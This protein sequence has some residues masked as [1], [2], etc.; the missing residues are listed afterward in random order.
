MCTHWQSSSSFF[1]G[2]NCLMS[3]LKEMEKSGLNSIYQVCATMIHVYIQDLCT[4][5]LALVKNP[6][7]ARRLCHVARRFFLPRALHYEQRKAHRGAAQVRA[8]SLL[9][10]KGPFLLSRL[11]CSDM[12]SG[13]RQSRGSP[14]STQ[15]SWKARVKFRPSSSKISG[16]DLDS[17]SHPTNCPA[18]L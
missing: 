13:A 10:P 3:R 18:V 14:F 16:L 8:R 9:S 6:Y 4:M 11:S 15:T 1:L 12:P 2:R 7:E 17:E 5:R